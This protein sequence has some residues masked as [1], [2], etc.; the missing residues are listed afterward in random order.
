MNKQ[1]S[2]HQ[3][4]YQGMLHSTNQSATGGTP[5]KLEAQCRV[6][7]E[8]HQPGIDFLSLAEVPKKI[9]GLSAKTAD[10]DRNTNG[11]NHGPVSQLF[12]LSGICTVNLWQDCC[13]K[14]NL[15]KS[16]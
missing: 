9:C 12:F 1:Q 5:N 3:I 6:L 14:G 13:G 7:Q 16:Y 8:N 10:L 4:H 11:Q 15:R 2:N